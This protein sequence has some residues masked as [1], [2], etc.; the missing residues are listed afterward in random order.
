MSKELD[1]NKFKELRSCILCKYYYFLRLNV[2]LQTKNM[3]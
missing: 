2:R 3:P 1:T